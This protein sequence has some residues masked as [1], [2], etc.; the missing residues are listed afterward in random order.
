MLS[1][2]LAMNQEAEVNRMEQRPRMF[3]RPAKGLVR[4]SLYTC[5]SAYFTKQHTQTHW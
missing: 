4:T 3:V 2:A 1:C 5:F